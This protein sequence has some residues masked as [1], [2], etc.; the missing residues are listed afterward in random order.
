[1]KNEKV[2]SSTPQKQSKRSYS[3][4]KFINTLG[5]TTAG[6]IAAPYLLSENVFGYGY[7]NNAS[8]VSQVAITQADR[9][10][11]AYVKK[12]SGPFI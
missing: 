5:S 3:R 4:R 1:M 7:Q 9:Y 2:L 8:Y 10:S 6:L 12:Q 11:R